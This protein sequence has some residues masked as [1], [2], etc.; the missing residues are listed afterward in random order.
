MLR[1]PSNIPP[2]YFYTF[3]YFYAFISNPNTELIVELKDDIFAIK[4]SVTLLK[5]GP[6]K[7]YSSIRFSVSFY[8]TAFFSAFF[9]AAFC[10]SLLSLILSSHLSISS[11]VPSVSV[12]FPVFQAFLRFS[13]VGICT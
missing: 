3:I 10:F 6:L 9:S 5:S 7:I 13:L 8:S 4:L 1:F 11:S 12:I 2:K